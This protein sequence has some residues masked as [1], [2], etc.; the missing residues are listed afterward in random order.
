MAVQIRRERRD[1]RVER[2]L[3][4]PNQYFEQARTAARAEVTREMATEEKRAR[5]RGTSG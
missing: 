4:D 3:R 1:D 5:H 2:I